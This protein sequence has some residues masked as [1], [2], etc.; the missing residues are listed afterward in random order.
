MIFAILGLEIL[1]TLNPNPYFLF[2]ISAILTLDIL[3]CKV[4]LPASHQKATKSPQD[5]LEDGH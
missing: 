2:V 5:V 3:F 1:F 4:D